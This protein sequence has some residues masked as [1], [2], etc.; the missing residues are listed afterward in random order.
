MVNHTYRLKRHS[1]RITMN[2]NKIITKLKNKNYNSIELESYLEINQLYVLSNSMK[3]IVR[4]QVKS[5]KVVKRLIE[6]GA[7]REKKHNLMGVYTIGHLSIATLLKLGI[8]K[9]ILECYK[10]LDA[11]DKDLVDALYESYDDVF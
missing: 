1:I 6:L 5:D 11:F 10:N 8:E 3:E 2:T 4:N 7:Y 9:D